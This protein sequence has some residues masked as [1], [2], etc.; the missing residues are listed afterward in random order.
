V[1]GAVV[2]K[3]NFNSY[4]KKMCGVSV[5]IEINVGRTIFVMMKAILPKI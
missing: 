3:H 2:K 5:N 4:N 1:A